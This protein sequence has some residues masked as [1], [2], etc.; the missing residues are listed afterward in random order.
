MKPFPQWQGGHHGNQ[1]RAHLPGTCQGIAEQ[2]KKNK[3][4]VVLSVGE[5]EIII[6]DNNIILIK[7]V[8]SI[9]HHLDKINMNYSYKS[10]YFWQ[11]CDAFRPK[12]A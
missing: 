7:R 3:F 9:G 6:I 10:D 11:F 1:S 4:F 2:K 12:L 8:A 5:K